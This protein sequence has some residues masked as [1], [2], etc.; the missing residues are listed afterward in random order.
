[1]YTVHDLQWKTTTQILMENL[2]YY[3]ADKQQQAIPQT[4]THD[5]GGNSKVYSVTSHPGKVCFELN[6]NI[7]IY[8]HAY[9]ANI[10]MFKAESLLPRVQVCKDPP[11]VQLREKILVIIRQKSK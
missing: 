2:F 7:S 5:L 4:T 9:N 11:W 6:T 8:Q 1:M 10:T 3:P